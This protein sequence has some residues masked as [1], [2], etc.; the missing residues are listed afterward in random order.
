MRDRQDR[1]WK[2]HYDDLATAAKP[3]LDYSNDRVQAQ[4]F[5]VALE[6]AGSIQ[7]RCCLD[8]GCGFGLL[9]MALEALGAAAVCGIDQSAV[10]INRNRQRTNSIE[11]IL[12]QALD[13]P[14]A[15]S[16]DLVF[17]VEVL[18]YL[19]FQ[20]TLGELWDHMAPGGRLVAVV[21]NRDCPLVQ[22]P[23]ERYEGQYWPPTV[24]EISASVLALPELAYWG[25]RGLQFAADQSIVPY[26][27][28]EWMDGPSLTGVPNRFVF[29]AGK[30]SSG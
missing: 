5:A 26:D 4:T 10:I 21:P 27:V 17:A 12:G 2:N 1:F 23:T 15:A 9:S 25:I 20:G 28:T 8:F 7:G 24:G 18:Q 22:C 29:V 3:W 6:A 19:S 16:Y 30:H 14:R 13:I 11:W